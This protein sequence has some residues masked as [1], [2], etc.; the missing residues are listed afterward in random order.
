MRQRSGTRK[1]AVY[2][3]LT[4]DRLVAVPLEIQRYGKVRSIKDMDQQML[5]EIERFF[6]S[7]NE[8]TGKKFKLI[9]F[10]P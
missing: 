2:I 1:D 3:A 4:N 6:G 5:A 9:A 10:Q 7:Y 8:Q